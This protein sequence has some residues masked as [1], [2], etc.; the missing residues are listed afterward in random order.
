MAAIFLVG[1]MLCINVEVRFTIICI[2]SPTINP[3]S[4]HT[5][6]LMVLDLE[7]LISNLDYIKHLAGPEKQV[8]ASIKANAYGHDIRLVA[9]VLQEMEV[10]MLATGSIEDART[11]RKNGVD[12][13]LLLFAYATPENTI[14]AAKEGFISTIPNLASAISLNAMTSVQIPV[15]L[16]IDCGLGRL[17]IP[18]S[19]AKELVTRILQLEKLKVEGIYTHVP[20][21]EVTSSAWAQERLD[22]F[23]TFIQA[24]E[25]DGY[26]IPVTQAMAS[27]C[28]L[29]G[30]RDDSS[31]ICIG[32]ALYG[33][34]P[35]SSKQAPTFQHLQPV[36]HSV[37]S[38]LIHIGHHQ[39]GSDIAVHGLYGTA[40]DHV[41]GVLP[42][43]AAMGMRPPAD[44]KEMF[45]LVKGKKCRVMAVS[46]EHI[47]I[48]LDGI[49]NVNIGDK[50]TII[51]QD[52]DDSL[53]VDEL[54]QA[55]QVTPLQALMSISGKFSVR[56]M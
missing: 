31:A 34:S 40:G 27:C 42:L 4:D 49:E 14:D 26:S 3:M 20:F 12:T 7:A 33:L 21:P 19:Q 44:N 47:S 55:W 51:G 36:I 45:V 18:L 22:Q 32:H 15:Y 43:G 13:P 52:G 1:A 53:S 11:L 6:N 41:V 28:V 8:I 2:L 56:S 35:F 10:D 54:A 37:S 17:G 25:S 9:S 48:D 16:K 24:L 50:A 38:T 5:E 23:D 30:L 39:K 46:L 29:A